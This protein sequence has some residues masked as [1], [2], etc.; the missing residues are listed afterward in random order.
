MSLLPVEGAVAIFLIV[1]D[2]DGKAVSEG[3]AAATGGQDTD[4]GMGNSGLH[5]SAHAQKS[6]GYA[7]RLEQVMRR[8]L[9]DL[10]LDLRQTLTETGVHCLLRESLC[11]DIC[12]YIYIYTGNLDIRCAHVLC[13]CD[14]YLAQF[15]M[16]HGSSRD[17][18]E[19]S[20]TQ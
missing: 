19:E 10:R 6:L 7:D 3:D 14:G 5:K 2:V 15:M 16:I 4:K 11:P 17:E 18:I 20:F 13:A 9:I 12:I 8:Q 1:A